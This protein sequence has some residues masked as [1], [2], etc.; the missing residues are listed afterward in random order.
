MPSYSS[1]I[2]WNGSFSFVHWIPLAPP[3]GIS[4]PYFGGQLLD[5]L[6][7][8]IELSFCQH[9]NVFTTVTIQY[10]FASHRV[11]LN[12]FLLRVV[13]LIFHVN[14]SI[15]LPIAN[16][17]VAGNFIEILLKL[18]ISLGKI[19]IFTMLSGSSHEWNMSLYLY[20]SSWISLISVV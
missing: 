2:C 1:T 17:N 7:C 8:S 12:L 18:C 16:E 3:S 20:T 11:I 10:V 5:S 13:P 14:F 15:I 6:F 4:W 9:H 19:S